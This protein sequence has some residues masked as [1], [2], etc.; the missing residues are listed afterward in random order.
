MKSTITFCFLL[1]LSINLFAQ[2]NIKGFVS[3]DISALAG[4]NI[5]IKNTSIGVVSDYDGNYE[6][7]AKQTDTLSISYL[8]YKTV[9]VLV[10]NQKKINTV[11]NGNIELD[12]VEI[13]A[14][15][16]YR[17]RMLSCGMC[18][19]YVTCKNFKSNIIT[20]SLYPNPSKDGRF[21]L[22]LLKPYKKVEIQISSMSAQTI[23][24]I[25][26]QN[27]NKNV[28]INLSQYPTGMYII[29]IIA[30]GKHLPS[31]KAIIGG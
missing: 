4:A 13:V 21:N 15:L 5:I 7:D 19:S 28:D 8:G 24:T 12:A 3:D 27:V 6:I 11:L 20:E 25:N 1:S 9:D 16:S 26:H 29:N 14:Y 23:K 31:K 30:D 2:T 17:C 18:I 22:N 10:E